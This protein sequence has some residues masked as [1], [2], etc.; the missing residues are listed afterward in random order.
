MPNYTEIETTE[1]D[2]T[3]IEMTDLDTPFLKGEK[4][5]PGTDGKD[6]LSAYELAL[7]NGFSGTEAEWIAS[8]RGE[9]GIS[10]IVGFE[11]RNGYL[12]AVSEKSENINKF[13][14]E[15]GHMIVTI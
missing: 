4:G 6:G 14:I 15:N 3:L 12:F 9:E 11:L 2:A 8:L 1:L 10:G 13:K 5:E 7:K